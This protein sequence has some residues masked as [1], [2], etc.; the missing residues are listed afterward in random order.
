MPK[1]MLRDSDET[2]FVELVFYV[3]QKETIE[4]LKAMDIEVE[5]NMVI[6]SRKI[7]AQRALGRINGEAVSVSKMKEAI[8]SLLSQDEIIIQK[9][10]KK[11]HKKVMKELDLKPLIFEP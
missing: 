5:D 1:E 6:L 10:G 11:G 7:T 8:N 9:L 2:A 4:K 3:D